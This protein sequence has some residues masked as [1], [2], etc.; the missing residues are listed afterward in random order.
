MSAGFLRRLGLAIML[1][2]AGA[3]PGAA[4]EAAAWAALKEGGIVLF[5]HALAPG[6][7]DPPSLRLGDCA[8]QRNLSAEGRAQARRIGQAFRARGVAVGAVLSSEWCRTLETAALAFPGQSRPEP[9]FNSFFNDRSTEGAQTR[10]ALAILSAWRGPGALVVST[11]QVNITAL[12]GVVPNSGEG[13]VVRIADG[14]AAMI[15]R[16]RP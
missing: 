14:R 3:G 11:H 4:S 9:A 8:T 10:A 15:G 6:T 12:T 1:W 7:G 2:V 5:R 16:I 13:L